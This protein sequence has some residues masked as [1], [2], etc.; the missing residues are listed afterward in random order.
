MKSLLQDL[1]RNGEQTY[2]PAWTQQSKCVKWT[3][4]SVFSPVF[5]QVG[6]G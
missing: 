1:P 3:C 5:T 6:W 4:Q 2:S